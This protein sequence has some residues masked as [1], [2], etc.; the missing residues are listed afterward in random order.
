ME[1][2]EK[3]FKPFE[4]LKINV[5][6]TRRTFRLFVNFKKSIRVYE[7]RNEKHVFWSESI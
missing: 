3:V 5:A 7:K 2:E 4:D 1:F 6:K